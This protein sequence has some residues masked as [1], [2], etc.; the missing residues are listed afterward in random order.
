MKKT[1]KSNKQTRRATTL[2]VYKYLLNEGKLRING[3][4]DKRYNN[5]LKRRVK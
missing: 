1:K 2:S 5:L 3:A 4:G